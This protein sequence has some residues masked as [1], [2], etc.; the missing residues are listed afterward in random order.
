MYQL[1]L[2]VNIF[3]IDELSLWINT[4]LYTTFNCPLWSSFNGK[5]KC[6]NEKSIILWLILLYKK[7]KKILV[8]KIQKS[9]FLKN[10]IMII[11]TILNFNALCSFFPPKVPQI[12]LQW[13]MLQGLLISKYFCSYIII[14]KSKGKIQEYLGNLPYEYRKIH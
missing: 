9:H 4:K 2:E 10:H 6:L 5:F 12:K 3:F 14:W 7:N 8:M 1:F 11:H 13:W